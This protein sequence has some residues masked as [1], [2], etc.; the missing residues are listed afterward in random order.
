MISLVTAKPS[1]EPFRR[2]ENSDTRATRS[3]YLNSPLHNFSLGNGVD[4]D[5]AI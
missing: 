3:A 4:T 1:Q 5:G 2:A